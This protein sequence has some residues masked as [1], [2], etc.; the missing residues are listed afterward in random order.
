[1]VCMQFYAIKARC[2]HL[3]SGESIFLNEPADFVS[4]ENV[5]DLVVG[6]IGQDARRAMWQATLHDDLASGAGAGCMAH[7]RIAFGSLAKVW[8]AEDAVACGA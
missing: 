7:I 5:W 8:Q 3:S 2:L 4:V 1:M 6:I